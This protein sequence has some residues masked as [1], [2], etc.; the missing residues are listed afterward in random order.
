MKTS[1]LILAVLV[2]VVAGC[3]RSSA[4]RAPPRAADEGRRT[5]QRAPE[6]PPSAQRSADERTGER[7]LAAGI[8][9][10]PQIREVCQIQ[11][12][13]E[14]NVEF[15][16]SNPGADPVLTAVTTCLATGPLQDRRVDIVDHADARSTERAQAVKDYFTGQGV[17]A[18]KVTT[19]SASDGEARPLAASTPTEMMI[20]RRVDVVLVPMP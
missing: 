1:H 18:D 4:D 2:T 20:E 11:I 19:H 12:G 15:D 6:Q 7:P 10:D 17:A 3:S 9:I 16:A 5:E 14:I 8:V 13:P